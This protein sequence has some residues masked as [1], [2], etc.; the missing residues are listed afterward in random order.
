MI[1]S[2]LGLIWIKLAR[3]VFFSVSDTLLGSYTTQ[4]EGHST[5]ATDLGENLVPYTIKCGRNYTSTRTPNDLVPYTIK[6]DRERPRT[7][8]DK[9][10]QAGIFLCK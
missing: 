9:T 3:Q 2:A 10:S 1:L 7:H 8:M 4:L 5:S 6:H